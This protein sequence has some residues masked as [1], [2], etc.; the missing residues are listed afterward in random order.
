[1]SINKLVKAV[2]TRSKR[3]VTLVYVVSLMPLLSCAYAG[4][5]VVVVENLKND[6][7]N[8]RAGLFNNPKDFTKTIYL[9][10]SIPAKIGSVSFTFIDLPLGKYAVSAFHDI[11]GSEK[12]DTNFVGKPVEPYGFSRDARGTFGPPLFEDAMIQVDEAAQ[13]VTISVK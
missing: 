3:V 8:V 1:M 5:L 10:K 12:L 11:N 9:G 6:Q 13:T 2:A 4:S 7:G